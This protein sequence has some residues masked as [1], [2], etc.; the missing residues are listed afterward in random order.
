MNPSRRREVFVA[1]AICESLENRRLL[2]AAPTPV[3]P[4]ITPTLQLGTP[5]QVAISNNIVAIV[6]ADFNG[7]DKSDLATAY[8]TGTLS[9]LLTA[10]GKSL[11]GHARVFWPRASLLLLSVFGCN[12]LRRRVS[13]AAKIH[14]A[15]P[16]GTFATGCYA[17]AMGL[18]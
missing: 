17:M 6:S 4:I 14:F 12:T 15:W 7:D 11:A 1:K 2:T 8:S 18:F 13:H 10:C 3:P 16:R 9:I 5:T